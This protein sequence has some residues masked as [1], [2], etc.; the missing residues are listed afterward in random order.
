MATTSKTA[1]PSVV[2]LA[3][4]AASVKASATPTTFKINVD[5]ARVLGT[6]REGQD[7]V[8]DLENG[9]K[10]RIQN[11]FANGE[12]VNEV[13]FTGAETAT[14]PGTS[15]LFG[16]LF[17]AGSE[18]ASSMGGTAG[19]AALGLGGV[20]A[21]AAGGGS[22]SSASNAAS[23]AASGVTANANGTVSVSGAATP[24]AAVKV[25]FPDGTISNVTAGVDGTYAATSTTPQTSGAVTVSVKEPNSAATNTSTTTFQDTT[26]PTAPAATT[27]TANTNGTLTVAGSTEPGATVKITFPDGTS[28]TVTAGTN[29]AY[30]A[31]STK[32]QPSGS[33][34]VSA[35]DAAGNTSPAAVSTFTD[36]TAPLTPVGTAVT[37][38][39]NGTLTVAGSAEPG[40]TV[41]VTFPDGT[42][43]SVTAGATGTYTA[44]SAAPQTSG[45]VSVKATDASGNTSTAAAATFTDTTAPAA[46]A[47]TAL[48][49]N[50]NGT[51]TVSGN[52]EPGSTVK[53]TFPDGTVASVTAAANGTYAATSAAPQTTGAVSIKSTDAAGNA[54]SVVNAVFA[55]ATAPAAPAST[56][57]PNAT[58]TLTV[59]GTAE[60][61]STVKVTFP[62]GTVASI[63]ASPT[64]AYS[65]TSAAPQTTGSVSVKATD[66]A[67]N[68]SAA[69][70]TAF[71]DTKAPA[72]PASTT[73]TPN[74]DG[75]LS[76][77]GSAEPGSTVKVT[78]PDGT[79]AS[80]TASPTGAY[81]A[82]SAAPQ[83]TGQVK[84]AATDAAGNTSAAVGLPFVDTSAPAKPAITATGNADGTVTVSGTAEPGS[85]VKVTFPD[86]T[87][88]SVTTPNGVFAVTSAASQPS[89]SVSVVAKDPAGNV[90]PAA[91]NAF[92]DTSA[93]AKPSLA[94]TANPDGTLSV[95]G[96]TE[97]GASVKVTFPDGTIANVIAG[98]TGAYSATS[99]DSQPSG[100]VSVIAKDAA[101]NVAPAATTGFADTTAPTKPS[102]GVAANAD[103]TL[104]VSG[105]AEPGST[106]KITFPD[107][108]IGTAT[109]TAAGTY[110]ATSATPQP[111]GSV[112]AI[113]K[114]PA[115][116]ASPTAT[117]TYADTSAPAKPTVGVAANADGTITVS[118]S[119]EPGS[120][121]KVTYPDG[122][123]ATA[124]AGPS[125]SFSVTSPNNQP[126]GN[127]SVV[128]KDP[129]GNASPAATSAYADS[130]PPGAPTLASASNT[131]G[132]LTVSGTAEPGSIV[133]VTFPDGSTANAV[134]GAN[135][136]YS[137]TSATAQPSGSVSAIA[138]DLGGNASP[139]ASAAYVDVTPPAKPTLATTVNADGTV[140]VSGSAEP[141]STVKVTFAD[142]TSTNATASA[143]GTYA[144]TSA[145]NQPSGTVSAI[146]KDSSGNASQ[147]ATTA[148]A[149]ASAPVKPTLAAAANAD[150][151][152]TVSGTAEPGSTIKVTFPDGTI[153]T[154]TAS[155]SGIYAVTSAAPQPSGPVSALAKDAAGNASPAASASY[156]DATAPT[157]PTLNQT[158]NAD[159]T[160]TVSGSAEPGTSVKVTFPDG[161]IATVVASPT[162]AYAATSNGNQPSGNVSATAKDAAGNVSP[163]MTSAYA[164]ATAPSKPSLTTGANADGTLTVS[165]NAEPG[166]AVTVTF[167]DGTSA[168]VT[169]NAAGS[170]A[171]TSAANQP[172][173]T[174]TAVAKDTAGN[175]SPTASATYADAIAPS[176]PT[177]SSSANADGTLTVSGT[178]EPGASVTVAYPDGTFG[179]VAAGPTGAYTATSPGIQPTGPVV[180]T[181][182]DPAGNVSAPGKGIYADGTAP[183]APTVALASNSDGTVTASGFTEPGA[184]VKVTFP[185]G[186]ST[187]VT[188]GA[189]G[190]YMATSAASQPSG[191]VT[192]VAKDLAGNASA[193]GNGSYV[194]ATAPAK[195]TLSSTANADG[196]LTVTGVGEPGASVKVTFP[197][198]TT[199][200][201][202][203]GPDG[204]YTTTSAGNQPSGTVNAVAT[205]AAGNKSP[206]A[207]AP[208]ADT[209]APN[210]PSLTATGNADGTLKVVGTAEAGALVKVTFPDGTTA[211]VTAGPTG[212]YSA[213]S[214]ASQPSGP[215]SA[216]TKDA[217]GNI[218]AAANGTYADTVT[219]SAPTLT[220]TPN[221]DG[222][223]TVAGFAEPNAVVKVTFPD[224]TIGTATA[225][226]SGSYAAT[227][228]A[229]QPSGAVSV[230]ATDAAGNVSPAG[231]ANYA[232]TIAP[233][234]PTLVSATNADGTLTVS[235]LAEP[236]SSVAVTFPDGTQAT[237]TAGANGA[238]AATSAAAQPS[239]S[240]AAV[241]TDA[242][243][244]HSAAANGTYSDIGAPPAPVIAHLAD[245]VGAV[246]GEI[247]SGT[248][249]DDA[250]PA[251]SGTAEAGATVKVYDGVALLGTALAGPT[252]AWSFTPSASLADGAHQLT[253]KAVDA[254]GNGSD[255]TSTVS[256]TVDT[257]APAAPVIAHLADDVALIIGNIAANGKTNDAKPA[258]SGTAEAGTT[259][260][261]YDGATLIGS[262]TADAAGAWSVTPTAALAEGS[263][264]LTVKAVDL[265]GNVSSAS[266]AFAFTVDTVTPTAPTFVAGLNAAGNGTL[267]GTA[268][269]GSTVKVYLAGHTTADYTTT[270]DAT[271]HWTVI[272]A[273][274]VSTGGTVSATA[275]DVA[276]NVSPIHTEAA[277]FL[278]PFAPPATVATLTSATSYAQAGYSVSKIGDF[279][280]DGIDDFVV[281]A[282]ASEAGHFGYKTSDQYIV[283]G[284]A[285]GV[286]S[287]SLDSLNASQGIH[288]TATTFKLPNADYGQ[289]GQ[290]VTN[291][292][293]INGDGYAD[294]GISSN[295][296][297]RAYAVFGRGGNATS[298]IDLGSID[299]SNNGQ[300]TADGFALVNWNTGAWM[301]SSMS[302]GDINGDGFGDIVVGSLDGGGNGQGQTTVYYGHA[303]NGGTAAWEN[304]Y[305][306][307]D[308]L[309]QIKANA[310]YGDRLNNTVASTLNTTYN[311]GGG[312]FDGDA[313]LGARAAVIADVN[314]D[315]YNDYIVT[316]PRADQ[317]G[318]WDT[319]TAYLMFGGK[320]GLAQ[321]DLANLQASQGV[322][323]TGSE[324]GE[325]LG[326][327][328]QTGVTTTQ[329][330]SNING[331]FSPQS[332]S[333]SNI[334]DINGD[335]IADFAVGS[336]G[337]GNQ[338]LDS[339]GPGRVYVVY[340]KDAGVNWAGLNL[341]ALDGTNGFI[342]QKPSAGTSSNAN[343]SV[344]QLGWSVAG[345]IDMNG[346]GVDDM[347]VSAPGEALSGMKNAGAVYIVYGKSGGASAFTSLNDLDAMVTAGTAK[348]LTGA[349]AKEYFG[350]SVSTGDFNGDGI[351][352]VA[353]GAAGVATSAGAT[354]ISYGQTKGFT[355][356]G[357]T[358]GDDLLSGAT[359]AGLSAIV[360]GV[361]RINGGQGN[362]V[363]HGIGAA[364]DTGNGGLFDVA[365][366]A[367]GNDTIG[368]A[369]MNFT[370]IDGGLGSD[371]LK[372]EGGAPLSIDLSALATRIQGFE[373]FDL[374]NSGSTLTVV[375]NDVL[376]QKSVI[377][378][379]FLVKGGATD[380]VALTNAANAQ[381]YATG[382]TKTIGANTFD[383]YHSTSSDATNANADV[384]IQQGVIVDLTPAAQ[385]VQTTTATKSY[386]Y[387]GAEVANIGDFNGDGITDYLVSAPANEWGHEVVYGSKQYVVYG[388][389]NGVPQVNLDAMTKDQ[390]IVLSTTNI[391]FGGVD[392]GTVGSTAAALG[393]INGDGY[394]DFAMAS[395]RGD[396]AQVIFGRGGNATQSIDLATLTA[397]NNGNATADGFHIANWNTGAWMGTGLSGSDINGDGYGDVLVGSSDA[398]GNGQYSVIYGHAGASGTASWQN[399][400]A[401]TDGLHN[402]GTNAAFGTLLPTTV[403]QTTD[404]TD[405]SAAN[406]TADSDLGD[407]IA[408]VGDVN[409]DGFSDYIVTSPR[410]DH[411]G[412]A[413]TGTAFLVFGSKTGL[414]NFDI[415]N[416]TAAQGVKLYGSEL[417]ESLGGTTV[418]TT[419]Q[420]GI[421]SQGNIAY[422]QSHSVANIGDINGDGIDDLAI[423]SPGWG[424]KGFY[425]SGAGRT[426]VMYGQQKGVAWSDASLGS[427]NGTTGFVLSKSSAGASSALN[428]N[429]NQLGW[430]IAGGGDFNGDGVDDFVVSAV[431]E[432]VGG[433]NAAGAAYV[434]YGQAGANV[435]STFTSSTDLDALVT[436]GKAAKFTGSAAQD[437]FGA[438]VAMGDFN[439]DGLA[440]IA[441]GA[442]GSSAGGTDAGQTRFIYGSQAHL[443]QAASVNGETLLAGETSTGYAAI[444][445]GVDRISGGLGNDT[446]TGIGSS[447][448]TGNNGLF[449]AAY[450]GA[451]ND[452]IEIVGT[453]VTRVDGGLGTD[454]LKFNASGIDLDL[455]AA[456]AK[457]QGFEAFDIGGTGANSLSLRL[458]DVLQQ[459]D[460]PTLSFQVLG[461][462]DDSVTLTNANGGTW[463]ATGAS[464]SINGHTFDVYHNSALVAANTQGDVLLEQSLQ[465]HVV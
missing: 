173:G 447:A 434:V 415:K 194:D 444:V 309:H 445:G 292:G 160:L 238:Y 28:A 11:Y 446:I 280:G 381:W 380:H 265:V 74:A 216:T 49:P 355:Q 272:A 340:G 361:D 248:I 67:G 308:G 31:T 102:L 12:N 184:S 293:D 7:L 81:S 16:D 21:A 50:T 61:G 33:V 25:T 235:G 232:D 372:V 108:T 6:H 458:A 213:T 382:A 395:N 86:G 93:P 336:P 410:A 181:A 142:G 42:T 120:T 244:N 328:Y 387:S 347:V 273:P 122:T 424:D 378:S 261:V 165:G 80:V 199:K 121:V 364:A 377:T 329:G 428:T 285:N 255:P 342:L 220:A 77:A 321:F 59:T 188:A 69:T 400:W 317:A 366:G 409:S 73:V 281:G 110:A 241:A 144:T 396:S 345:G 298:A 70:T 297:D 407:R 205:D 386:A 337:W 132:T 171:A 385:V 63:T 303:G 313:D 131:D 137:A 318:T 275:T 222:T 266:T 240:I 94:T 193:I 100:S 26:A 369:G 277:Q 402:V 357:S 92:A 64:G 296:N 40:S 249:T 48:T 326:G 167:P 439:G 116:N 295:A 24:G 250:K 352:D 389:Q 388:D 127:V 323:L 392:I 376:H 320:N 423:G 263:H 23:P 112:S 427:L 97:P 223:L 406:Y 360:G 314:G 38:N 161:T 224:G 356:V 411:N 374:A 431:G 198:G 72:T 152:V 443:T 148:Y 75:T 344:N 333:V 405:Y 158:A 117:N 464:K 290:T 408:V 246:M 215:V 104:T 91:T 186:T 125:G 354:Y 343:T 332:N 46:P 258:I 373:T 247:A 231:S 456:G 368:I 134:A 149:D 101:G 307:P 203:A 264:T 465:V 174:A 146:A 36:K 140:T 236:N 4:S 129:A 52:A 151:T 274:G 338:Q 429:N 162:G 163:A 126:S 463:A 145:T 278:T 43:A 1:A 412:V 41:K 432:N 451:G 227:S 436:S 267:T 256:F 253:V 229:N 60:P 259:V 113:A 398:A 218:S 29:G 138:K 53:V 185:D 327:S 219:P 54:A 414:G 383:V 226:T 95:S 417:G 404:T 180:V 212:A 204:A 105:V 79:I 106:V 460:N 201:V 358:N 291:L 276:G 62:D 202:G 262:T 418:A 425:D 15:S 172:A 124:T 168:N 453:N 239:G 452:S 440:D 109:A 197:D 435:A 35:T 430:S 155:P 243:G 57:T 403:S 209:T 353:I 118:G 348:K 305:A 190:I 441:V 351:G 370:R 111:S 257:T 130:T 233:A 5:P 421:A 217:A 304:L 90:S 85:T 18:S 393:D 183:T 367:S 88:A 448:D 66:A 294:V 195:L 279:N 208:Y 22:K 214:I 302:G 341:G 375:A 228:A 51:L 324:V 3:Q 311:A 159:G 269:A 178:A 438:S 37:P 19:L 422:G 310:G 156:A 449:D 78:F 268:E 416:L 397:S 210:A 30:T 177:L 334:G 437:H 27:T 462:A 433:Q 459:K 123:T 242:A 301:G 150:G 270:A 76:V 136:L 271:G 65:A 252:G 413:D 339:N 191:A 13:E 14:P 426:Y 175:I 147:V 200:T 325:Q 211:T 251:L 461:G 316:A 89:G 119:A 289:T 283:Y 58:G 442:P 34:S 10:K 391:K 394:A 154:A 68:T 176:K 114:D 87:T 187:T 143:A 260:N 182:K 299:A 237:V 32:P 141:G 287:A 282:P 335:S 45:A 84:V 196:T 322:R 286:P 207:S 365:Y 288:I 234:K 8:I 419:V 457:V 99:V 331:A 157:K 47:G 300:A 128:A 96:T 192:A 103:G 401:A 350:S 153:G 9:E 179:T 225:S 189:N 56:V 454:T 83:G 359:T 399:L 284:N 221:P 230:K 2:T 39:V 20:V 139:A 312:T 315:G 455:A 420:G 362:D 390:G 164:D 71:A 55:D 330:V 17:A 206:A 245:D 82:T 349:A 166:S 170:Y 135:G 363:I 371:T 450:G 254:A 107:G 306:S 98:P 384:L 44:T 115:G 133:K 169:A 346:D 319:G 379:D